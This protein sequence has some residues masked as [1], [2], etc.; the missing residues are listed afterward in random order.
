MNSGIRISASALTPLSRAQEI[1]ANNL[2]NMSTPGYRAD[3][4]GFER[5]AA[6][7]GPS[8]TG[9]PAAGAL[10][11]GQFR[12]NGPSVH[13]QLVLDPAALDPTHR[14]LDVALVGD[15][16]FSVQA[17]TGTAYT[18]NGSLSRSPE[19]QLLHSSGY[20]ILADG[21][22][23]ELP[24]G[25]TFG[26]QADGMILVDGEAVGRLQVVAFDDASALRHGGRGLLLSDAP[27]TNLEVFQVAQGSLEA[28]N[29][30]PVSTMIEMMAVLRNYEANQSALMTQ[31][32][33]VAQ[34]VR[35]ASS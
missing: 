27:G 35:W 26:V 34:L 13:S 16:F 20:P 24:E 22:P 19:G 4:V 29:V 33:S 30:D 8:L 17:E 7:N 12:V 10:P 6:A 5:L 31:D 32:Q 23:V 25:A 9:E 15:G 1:L 21:G 3:H 18:R 14:P 11:P 28:S 2:A